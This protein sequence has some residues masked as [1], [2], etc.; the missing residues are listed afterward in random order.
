MVEPSAYGAPANR[1][2]R[3]GTVWLVAVSATGKATGRN[4]I[5]GAASALWAIPCER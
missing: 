1:A 2:R 3:I 4:A 5:A